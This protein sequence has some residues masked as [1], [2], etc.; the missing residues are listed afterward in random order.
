V[1]P[2]F[3]DILAVRGFDWLSDEIDT[4]SGNGGASHIALVTATEPFIQVTE[5]LGHGITVRSWEA[6]LAESKHLWILKSP[7]ALPD[8][9]EACRMAIAHVGDPY[10]YG[11]IVWQVMDDL[12]R[13]RWFTESMV[14]LNANRW[15]CSEIATF[16][17]AKLGLRPDDSTPNDMKAWWGI[18][19]W[20]VEQAL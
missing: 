7:L 2:D 1:T 10:A 3:G 13:S 18:E 17:E 5:A 4:M 15:I 6:R 14:H 20:G 9:I 19:K 8:R 11:N 12:T 16:C